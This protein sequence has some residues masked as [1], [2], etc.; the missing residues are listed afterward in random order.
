M[1]PGF[2]VLEHPS[3]LGIEARGGTLAE[4]FEQAGAG[5]SSVICD[6][7]SVTPAEERA[8][9]LSA[10]DV[11]QLLV[12]WLSEILFLFDARHWVAG[13][14]AINEISSSGLKATL[15]GEPLSRERHRPRLD[16][17]AVTYHQLSV[18][19]EAGESVLT[20]FFDI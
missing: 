11:H 2:R 19:Q 17:K 8:V 1:A 4:A 3:D 9:A 18:R 12:R 15:R 20:V 10:A 13:A 14:F 5:L 16:V 6:L 7:S